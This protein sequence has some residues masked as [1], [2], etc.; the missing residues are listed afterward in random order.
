[1]KKINQK[2]TL[3]IALFMFFGAFS[4][5]CNTP[6]KKS[7]LRVNETQGTGYEL[8]KIT[9]CADRKCQKSS[10]GFEIKLKRK[11]VL[12]IYLDLRNTGEMNV[13][14]WLKQGSLS[15]LNV[16]VKSKTGDVLAKVPLNYKAIRYKLIQEIEF[17]AVPYSGAA[18][19]EGAKDEKSTY[20]PSRVLELT[21][22]VLEPYQS[23][24][25]E[26]EY[27]DKD[28]IPQ[29]IELQLAE[30]NWQIDAF[31]YLELQLTTRSISDETREIEAGKKDVEIEAI[32]QTWGGLATPPFS[33]TILR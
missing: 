23:I 7:I 2:L 25:E 5:S 19:E 11:N 12:L 33:F 14:S 18:A 30:K 32:S 15:G 27:G 6:P 17:D 3:F 13:I 10:A 8:D 22:Q 9:F 29:A 20:D 16:V 28:I 26:I 31:I 24:T 4:F 1:M 21:K